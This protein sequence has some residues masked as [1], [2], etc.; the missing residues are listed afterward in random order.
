MNRKRS[1]IFLKDILILACT[2]F[3]GP[4]VHLMMMIDRL[5]EKRRYLTE[6]ELLELQ[7]LC[8]VLP[9]PTSTQ[10]VVALAYKMRGAGF[11][12][13]TLLVWSL[14]AMSLMISA[15]IGVHYLEKNEIS[16]SFTRFI[17]PM[18]VAFLIHGGYKIASKVIH[19]ALGWGLFILSAIFIY[20]YPSPYNTPIVIVAGAIIASLQFGK[21]ERME[22]NRFSVNWGNLALWAGVLIFAASLGALTKALPIRL[23]ENFY[24]NGSM[25]FG[26]G[27]V[28]IPMLYNEFVEFK[29]MM[30]Q[31]EFL[32]GMALT[33]LVPGP[34]F[35][36]ATYVGSI[37]MQQYGVGGQIIG[38]V[39]A[40]AGIFLPG[41][42]LI[43]FAYRIWNQLKQFRG[44]RASLEG[45]HATSSGLTIAAAINMIIPLIQQDKWSPLIILLTLII[46]ITTKIPAYYLILGGLL[47]GV[48]F[49]V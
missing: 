49:Q 25:V 5:V 32:S 17:G 48:L 10:T 9:G 26:G 1:I 23:F 33:Q 46:V 31:N 15:A 43:F 14:P 28:L 37:V 24:R 4:Q 38:G 8:Q 42:F 21:Q 41:V 34:V 29:G 36:I 39:M 18:A 40:T 20:F 12:Y 45:I 13:L 19:N 6:G 27:Q 3:G 7:A 44:V 30:T 22:K 11:A 2:A 47:I 35:S 16:L